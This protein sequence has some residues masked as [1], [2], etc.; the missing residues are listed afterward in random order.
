ML[1]HNENVK[2]NEEGVRRAES[3]DENFAFFMESTSIEYTVQRHCTLKQYGG[4]LDEKGYGI[5]MRKSMLN[6]C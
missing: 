2:E 4:K 3:E 6:F 1:E 5:A